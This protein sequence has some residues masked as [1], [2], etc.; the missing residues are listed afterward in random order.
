MTT[1]YC[2]KDLFIFLGMWFLRGKAIHK[3]DPN[4]E[5]YSVVAS[6]SVMN[7]YVLLGIISPHKDY[8]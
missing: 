8:F 5:I 1:L 6:N 3:L 7:L 2:K 4:K